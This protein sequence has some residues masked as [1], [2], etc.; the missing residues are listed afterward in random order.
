MQASKNRNSYSRLSEHSSRTELYENSE[1]VRVSSRKQ[2]VNLVASVPSN[3]E[4]YWEC[5]FVLHP[6]VE[7]RCEFTSSLA[8]YM[9]LWIYM[10]LPCVARPCN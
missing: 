5:I 10:Y 1:C 6:G 7:D 4:L 8:I 3:T 2:D 9:T